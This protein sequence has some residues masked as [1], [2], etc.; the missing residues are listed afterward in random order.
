MFDL[1]TM[2]KES[3]TERGDMNIMQLTNEA[4]EQWN[5]AIIEHNDHDRAVL[6]AFQDMEV[7]C[8]RGISDA[9]ECL[10]EIR[11]LQR[12]YATEE[13]DLKARAQRA[14]NEAEAARARN[15]E[16][17]AGLEMLG[18]HVREAY[19]LAT[20]GGL[21]TPRS[22]AS[23]GRGIGE[24][25]IDELIG[26]AE[27]VKFDLQERR[28]EAGSLKARIALA[29]AEAEEGRAQ[30]AEARARLEEA[31]T[32]LSTLELSRAALDASA[33]ESLIPHPSS[34]IPHPPSLIPRREV[35]NQQFL[36]PK[37]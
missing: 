16:V 19:E 22:G 37:P 9:L 13:V 4:I 14:L 6:N 27:T 3:A 21:D 32:R 24:A 34:P 18:R 29:E 8:N 1:F 31:K 7:Q 36:N 35:L 15:T 33:G 20:G 5:K 23:S 26:K 28:M 10:G 2:L 25:E 17:M 11:V 30:A 12:R